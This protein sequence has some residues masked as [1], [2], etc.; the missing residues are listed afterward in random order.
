[1]DNNHFDELR[2]EIVR[3][4]SAVNLSE[5]T[6]NKA[7]VAGAL[8]KLLKA[9]GH[10]VRPIRWA[11]DAQQAHSL[12]AQAHAASAKEHLKFRLTGSFG[13]IFWRD[14]IGWEAVRDEAKA[15][16]HSGALELVK[17]LMYGYPVR[18]SVPWSRYWGKMTGDRGHQTSP[19]FGPTWEVA[20]DAL[21]Y[22]AWAAAECMWVLERR[23][24]NYDEFPEDQFDAQEFH[25]CFFP[26]VDAYEA[27]LW[28]FWLTD[29]EVIALSRP[30][31]QLEGERVHSDHG[32]AVRW[33]EGEEEYFVLHDVRVPREIVET[34]ASEL[35]PQLILRERNAEVRREIVR[36]IGIERVCEGLNA[37][38]LDSQGNYE[39][40]LLDIQDGRLRPYLKM[41]NPSIG[42][43]HIEG[44]A[45]ECRTVA[46]ALAWRNQT[47][48]PP[49]VLT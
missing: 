39:L 31:V 49:S 29:A 45:P 5:V 44:V 9:M 30:I 48:V 47:D 4:L 43:Y 10:P 36:K 24:G 2:R 26:I 21:D 32:P 14:H 28:L 6:V 15:A 23:A 37:K 1:M 12:V 22:A 33:P 46:E 40:L 41:K 8:E 18:P 25:E 7:T 11:R 42:V 35:D 20:A 19:E 38:C 3:R 13:T 34:P 27:G 16:A 17:R